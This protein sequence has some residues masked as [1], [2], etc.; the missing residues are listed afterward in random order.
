MA[1]KS[2]IRAI[3]Y[4]IF[5]VISFNTQ[6]NLILNGDFE[7]G[8]F[9]GWDLLNLD[10]SL[11]QEIATAPVEFIPPLSG[12]SYKIRPGSQ[13]ID[14]GIS[15]SVNTIAGGIYNWS[16]D[17]AAREVQSDGFAL[18]T[19]ELKLDGLTIATQTLTGSDPFSTTF[20]GTYTALDSELDFQ[21]IF[22]R[23]LHSFTAH[24]QWFADNALFETSAIPLPTAF[25]LIGTGLICLIGNARCKTPN[26]SLKL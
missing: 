9:T 17:I 7:T 1:I 11:Q 13:A 26:L 2:I 20:S 6:A 18:G 10:T 22:N 5:T 21:L 24:P 15:Q 25:L 14:A 8:D 12:L 4:V 16:I 23:S 3:P 19:F